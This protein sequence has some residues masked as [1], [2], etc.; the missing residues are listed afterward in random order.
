LV[1]E[2]GK[3]AAFLWEGGRALWSCLSSAVVV[4]VVVVGRWWVVDGGS[5][6]SFPPFQTRTK[7]NH[8]RERDAHGNRTLSGI[9]GIRV[10][11]PSGLRGFREARNGEEGTD[12]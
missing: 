11:R 5:L 9:R 4:V 8:G 10:N 1:V 7:D 6:P 12:Q 2:M 3:L